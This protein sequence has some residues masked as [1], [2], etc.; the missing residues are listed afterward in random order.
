MKNLFKILSVLILMAS[1]LIYLS[2]CE[3][4]PDPPTLTTASVSAITQT[5]ATSGGSITSDGGAGITERGVCW[6]TSENPT[7]AHSKTSDGQGT[8]SFTS[9]LSDLT[10]GTRYYVRAYATNEAGTSYGN[11]QTFTTGEILL[12]TLT[13][14]D[15]SSITLTSAVSGGDI[16]DDG[17]ADISMKGVCWSTSENPTIDDSKT[18]DGSGTD[19]FTSDL[20]GL[21]AGTDYYVRAYATNSAGTAYGNQL[22][23]TTEPIQLATLTTD[24]ASSI[25]R[26]SA[27]SGGNISDDGGADIS[28]RGV[29]WSTSE[30]P[31]VDDNRTE[32][33]TGT[34][35]FTSNLTGLTAGTDYYVRAYATNSAGTAYGNQVTFTSAPI[36]LAT[37]STD[38]ASSITQT[39][40]VS[41]GNVTDDGGSG[42]T[43][44]GICWSTTSN[45][46][47]SD[48]TTNDGTGTGAFTSS[49][50]GLTPGTSYYVRAYAVNAAGTA[51]GNEISFDTNPVNL[52][53]VTTVEAS[54]ITT[55][56]AVAGGN[57]TDNGGGEITAKGI[58][59]S[60][61]QAPTVDDELTDEGAGMGS[62]TSSLSGLSDGTTY[63]VRAYAIN[64][65]GTSYGNEI[66][67]TTDQIV[68]ATLTTVEAS[69]ITSFTAT[70]GGNVTDNGGGD[71]TARGICWSTT[72]SPTISDNITTDGTGIGSFT[73]DISGLEA[74]TSYFVRAYA[75]N[76]AGTAYGNEITFTTEESLTDVDGNVYATVQIG[77]QVWMADPLATSS[78]SDGT[79]I[80][81]VSDATEWSNLTT[82]GYCFYDNDEASYGASYGALYNWYA[83]NA[84]NL[85]PDG[86]RI[87]T[88][89]DWSILESYIG[90]SANGGKLKETGTLHWESPNTGA[91]NETGF[92]ALPGG[93]RLSAGGFVNMGR[94]GHWWTP[95]E[96]DET[97]AWYR[98][99]SY[100]ESILYTARFNKKVGFSI[101]CIQ[102]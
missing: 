50:S 16:S 97:F 18:E 45:P 23:F 40:A 44:K 64:S 100:N 7:I 60:I 34:G 2:S 55:S 72:A 10:P 5:S 68:L 59:W 79:A 20:T 65:A 19:S 74:S 80:P 96:Y 84:G 22:T 9:D 47:T 4:E 41:G 66:S 32:D 24:E 88:A 90:G 13:T 67:F 17:G 102:E 29:C 71:I 58:C 53:S 14:T 94:W 48:N 39:S 81:L 91:T 27:V 78:Y 56:S 77:P 62:F 73:S 46:T 37:V 36:E 52:A 21:T 83:V 28:V 85:C 63:Y 1:S 70:S 93:Y 57:V 98:Y 15:V 75:T 43:A 6:N 101:R 61:S 35:S 31:T 51:Y 54:S 33:G 92:T 82:P 86:W 3:K 99:L 89:D 69:A 49:L 26:T 11:Q 95:S 38:E 8:G 87:P 25:T 12:P 42:I 30:N 76:S